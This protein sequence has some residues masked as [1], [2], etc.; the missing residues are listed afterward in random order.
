MPPCL[1]T[2]GITRITSSFADTWLPAL[3]TT[4]NRPYPQWRAA[5]CPVSRGHRQGTTTEGNGAIPVELGGAA[6]YERTL[7]LSARTHRAAGVVAAMTHCP[8]W[9][10]CV[11]V[12]RVAQVPQCCGS[13]RAATQRLPQRMRGRSQR[14]RRGFRGFTARTVVGTVAWPL[15]TRARA[16]R[17]ESPARRRQRSGWS[18]GAIVSSVVRARRRQGGS[19]LSG[20]L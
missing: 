19:L 6:R 15:D 3:S 8:S 18:D 4:N 7:P 9:H 2:I 16:A 11:A 20:R 12:H 10:H 14:G 17:S 1:Q 5:Q 13:V